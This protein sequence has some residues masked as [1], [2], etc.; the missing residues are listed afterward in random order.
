MTI[1]NNNVEIR[2]NYTNYKSVVG[3][4]FSVEGSQGVIITVNASGIF[5]QGHTEP[6][7]TRYGSNG[8][9]SVSS[10]TTAIKL[11]DTAISLGAGTW[12]LVAGVDFPAS[13]TGI[14]TIGWM[15]DSTTQ[16]A[17]R[18]TS[19]NAGA[20]ANTRLQSITTFSLTAASEWYIYGIQNSG[21][22]MSVNYYWQ[23]VRIA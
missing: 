4:G 11:N 19:A 16:L 18:I 8:T 15:K 17:S 3:G 23:A 10:G 1:N 20:G 2:N 14:R 12:M 21:S 13:S 22:A 7:G 5:I 9:K 6:I